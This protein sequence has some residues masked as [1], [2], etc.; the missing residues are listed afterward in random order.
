MTAAPATFVCEVEVDCRCSRTVS[1]AKIDLFDQRRGAH[2][3]G[4]AGF[5]SVSTTTGKGMST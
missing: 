3:P 2:R 4:E 1:F 5:V